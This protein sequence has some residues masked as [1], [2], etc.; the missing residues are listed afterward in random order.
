[1]I[2][3]L[4]GINMY[5]IRLLALM[6]EWRVERVRDLPCCACACAC[7]DPCRRT[8]RFYSPSRSLALIAVSTS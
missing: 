3:L 4:T 5:V 2:V 8:M 7:C 6:A 1:L